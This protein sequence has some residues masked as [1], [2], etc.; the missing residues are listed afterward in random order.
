MT[1][2]IKDE[3]VEVFIDKVQKIIQFIEEATK[4]SKHKVVTE[5]KKAAQKAQLLKE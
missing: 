1:S 2:A 4:K 3:L 5:Q